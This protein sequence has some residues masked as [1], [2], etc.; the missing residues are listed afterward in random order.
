VKKYVFR[1]SGV[2]VTEQFVEDLCDRIN[3]VFSKIQEFDDERIQ[4]G[5]LIVFLNGLAKRLNRVFER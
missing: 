4:L 2:P 3:G 5:V 1:L